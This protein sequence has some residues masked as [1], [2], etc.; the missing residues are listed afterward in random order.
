MQIL[1]RTHK[2]LS[3]IMLDGTLNRESLSQLDFFLDHILDYHFDRILLNLQGIRKLDVECLGYVVR[4]I[5]EIRR[6]GRDIA[7]T[8]FTITP[9]EIIS[10]VSVSDVIQENPDWL[11]SLVEFPAMEM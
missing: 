5:S 4:R 9:R 10:D 2:N 11:Y 7:L 1:H 8:V 6:S 3:I